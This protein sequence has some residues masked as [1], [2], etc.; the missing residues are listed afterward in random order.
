MSKETE[1]DFT[2][3]KIEIKL[4]AAEGRLAAAE[5]QVRIEKAV[6]TAF[7]EAIQEVEMER[8][9]LAREVKKGS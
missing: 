7:R 9:R 8:D 1:K 2:V 3:E 6:I 5:M 4:R